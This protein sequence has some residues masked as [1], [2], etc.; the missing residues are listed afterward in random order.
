[1]AALK[2]KFLQRRLFVSVIIEKPFKGL[3]VYDHA[4]AR[5]FIKSIACPYVRKMV[6]LA[7]CQMRCNVVTVEVV[8]SLPFN[9][10]ASNRTLFNR[11]KGN[12]QRISIGGVLTTESIK[13]LLTEC[14]EP[15]WRKSFALCAGWRIGRW[16]E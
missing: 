8:S 7:Y 4:F 13:S 1:L 10:T 3:A 9:I 16:I 11:A 6:A 15:L 2:A 14:W 12:G 5:I